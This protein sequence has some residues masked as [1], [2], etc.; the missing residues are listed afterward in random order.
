VADCPDDES[1][2]TREPA[3]PDRDPAG[4]VIAQTKAPA[5]VAVTVEPESVPVLHAV[6]V[7]EIPSNA[8]VT[9]VEAANPA[10]VTVTLVPIT[11]GPFEERLIDHVV[12]VNGAVAVVPHAALVAVTGFEPEERPVGTLITQMNPPAAVVVTVAPARVPE[13]Q[14][15]GVSDVPLIDIVTPEAPAKFVPV[16][17]TLEPMTPLVGAR[18]V[19]VQ[20]LTANAEESFCPLAESDAII[21]AAV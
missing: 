1:D 15:V 20:S 13:L 10:P 17:V 16:T 14:L 4:I 9:P 7:I 6:G 2:A 5:A 19:I 12:T 8:R 3:A 11:P 18:G 21:I